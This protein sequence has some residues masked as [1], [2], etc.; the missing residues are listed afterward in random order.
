MIGYD[1][2]G[3]QTIR[4]ILEIVKYIFAHSIFPLFFSKQQN[5]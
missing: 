2:T 4:N 3:F 1:F 5:E